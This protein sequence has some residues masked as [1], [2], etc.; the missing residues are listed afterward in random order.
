MLL[1]LIALVAVSGVVPLLADS[2][3]VSNSSSLGLP[4]GYTGPPVTIVGPQ[5]PYCQQAGTASAS[6]VTSTAAFALDRGG[7][8][9][10][11]GYSSAT[12]AF[13][14][15]SGMVDE[16]E[17]SSGYFVASFGDNVIVSGGT[18]N[19]TL[20]SHYSLADTGEAV[21]GGFGI[22]QFVQGSTKSSV[23]ATNFLNLGFPPF[24]PSAPPIPAG[25]QGAGVCFSESFDVSS[26]IQFGDALPLGA[27][28]YLN[29]ED[30]EDQFTDG[31]D[32][33]EADSTV[34]LT[35]YTVLD[36][37]GNVVADAEVT[38]QNVAGLDL[39]PAPEPGTWGLM[40]M[41]LA[42]LVIWRWRRRAV[43]PMLG[44]MVVCG[45]V[46][47]RANS[48]A[49]TNFSPNGSQ[50]PGIIVD[51]TTISY[52]QQS[53]SSSA[54]CMTTF[55]GHGGGYGYIDAG[56]NISASAAFGTLRGAMTEQDSDGY[57]LASFGDNVVVTGASGAGTLVAHY[58]LVSEGEAQSPGSAS[59]SFVQGSTRPRV[60]ANYV[61]NT[62]LPTP[63][64]SPN[65]ETVGFCFSE[66]FDVT[67]PVQFGADLPLGAQMYVTSPGGTLLPPNGDVTGNAS[68]EL[69]GYTV[70]DGAGNV[71]SDAAVT[72][73]HVAE[74]DLFPAPEP[75]TWALMVMGLVGLG[76]WRRFRRS[77]PLA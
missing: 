37:S 44:L 35:G 5:T 75:R 25:C 57:L 54:S 13:G 48:V 18:G 47:L 40:L 58:S 16:S 68:V 53:S 10:G 2:V 34:K 46:Q 64:A 32:H 15:L 9:G 59:Y 28:T 7:E 33:V 17:P 42:G 60:T 24:P 72:Q 8:F 23:T 70:L 29:S 71:V 55:G 74:L 62:G 76:M 49:V 1:S 36:A 6:C 45:A 51:G 30:F 3:F 20:I 61:V 41:G 12:A 22:F 19:G 73:Q 26:P 50:Y 66:S 27:Q 14:G 21:G 65:C 69:T 43:L 67:S 63:P 11:G 56:G 77:R 52:C 38:R 31:V 39:F 4:D